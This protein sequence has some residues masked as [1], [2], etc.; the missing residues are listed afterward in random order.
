MKKLAEYRK[1]L[2]SGIGVTTTLLV[3]ALDSF[4]ADLPTSVTHWLTGG[5][6]LATAVATY[7]TKNVEP[8]TSSEPAPHTTLAEP[9][10]DRGVR[11]MGWAMAGLAVVLGGARFAGRAGGG[12]RQ[13]H[14][15]MPFALPLPQGSPFAVPPNSATG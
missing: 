10:V 13:P 12:A 14:P 11:H 9:A 8:S 2:V 6:A 15:T 1:A 5:V 7:Y 4:G 3:S